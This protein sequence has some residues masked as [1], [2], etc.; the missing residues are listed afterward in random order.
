MKSLSLIFLL[1]CF[2]FIS[3]ADVTGSFVVNGS[4]NN[5]YPIIFSDG[6]WDQNIATEVTIARSNVHQDATWRGAIVSKFRF[7]T[8]NWG[9]GAQFI[10]A[11]IHQNQTG[12][13][14]TTFVGG[15]LDITGGNGDKKIVIWLRGGG[16]TYYYSANFAVSPAVYDNVANTLPYNITNGGTVTYKTAPDAIVN[17]K[18]PTFNGPVYSYDNSS[19]NYF[20]GTVSVGTP[21]VKSTLTVNGTITTGKVVVTQTGWPDYV[22]DSTYSLRPLPA[23][24]EYIKANKHLPDVQSADDVKKNGVELS[25][26]QAMLLKKIEELTLYIIEQNKTITKLSG[27]LTEQRERILKLEQKLSAKN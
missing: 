19:N 5:Y 1:L 17:Q 18:G 16:T 11:D 2:T 7:H 13:I 23:V 15:W 6:G 20:A 25:N 9:H 26:S 10:D 3:K 21:N 4:I 24:E 14:I 22:F 27:D 12:G 8:T